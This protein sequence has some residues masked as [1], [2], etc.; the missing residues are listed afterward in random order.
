VPLSDDVSVF[1]TRNT[2]GSGIHTHKSILT[3]SLCRHTHTL[4]HAHTHPDNIPPTSLHIYTHHVP[5]AELI[6]EVQAYTSNNTRDNV[7]SSRKRTRLNFISRLWPCFC[8]Q[9]HLNKVCVTWKKINN[10]ITSVQFE[11]H[12]ALQEEYLRSG[13]GRRG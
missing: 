13:E 7:K 12:R 6:Y 8:P 4:T 5:A 9:V 10:K 2:R 3:H 1:L 11:M